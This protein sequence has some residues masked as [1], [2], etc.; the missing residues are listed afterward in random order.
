MMPR[1]HEELAVLRSVI[2]ASLFDYP[3]TLSQLH[4]SLIGVRTTAETIP[5]WWRNSELLRETVEYRDGLFFPAG[6]ADLL[7]TRRRREAVSRGLLDDDRRLLSLASNMPFVRMV[8]VS[9]SLAHLN[10]EGS[11]DL[12]LFVI[13][14]PRRVWLV[15]VSILVIAKLLGWRRRICLNYVVSER[16]TRVEP[17]DL[18]SANQIVHLRPVK[19]EAVFDAFVKSNPFVHDFYPNFEFRMAPGSDGARARPLFERLLSLGPAQVGERVSRTLYGWHLRRRAA[20]WRS[21]DQVRLEAECLKLHTSSHRAATLERFDRAVMA[22]LGSRK[23][24]AS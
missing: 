13:T 24:L 7:D 10:A 20:R 8:A 12:D 4:A 15:T 17:E 1:P 3:L 22:A 14:A 16:A 2:Y 18:F 21:R 9:G 5:V 6:R 19:G 23:V 11:A